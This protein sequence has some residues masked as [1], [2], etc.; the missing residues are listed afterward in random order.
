L[1]TDAR[2]FKLDREFN[3]QHDRIWVAK[4]EPVPP[5]IKKRFVPEVYV[6]VGIAYGGVVGPFFAE[7]CQCHKGRN[8]KFYIDHILTPMIKNVKER[9]EETPDVSTTR[10]FEDLDDWTFQQDRA[11]IHTAKATQQF[12]QT[13]TPNFVSNKEAPTK[14]V[15]WP[16]ENY[17]TVLCK[18]VYKHGSPTTLAGLKSAIQQAVKRT[19]PSILHAYFDSMP[20]RLK[21]VIEAKSSF[22]KY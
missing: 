1:N 19:A 15:E 13:N 14:L 10:L 20:D 6:Y 2:V 5:I 4:G 22:T 8:H 17:W 21:A 7:T 3:P 18:E 11:S 9:K 16:V 12:L